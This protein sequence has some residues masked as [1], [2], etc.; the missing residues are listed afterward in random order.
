[1]ENER[2]PAAHSR[3]PFVSEA[4]EGVPVPAAAAGTG[5]I[6]QGEDG[7]GRQ[8][9][10]QAV[11]AALPAEGE[12]IAAGGKTV[13]E[14]GPGAQRGPD[15]AVGPVAGLQ[16]HPVGRAGPAEADPKEAGIAVKWQAQVLAA[17]RTL[18]QTEGPSRSQRCRRIYWLTFALTRYSPPVTPPN[19]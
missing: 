6:A 3:V 2:D 12:Q 14:T 7:P 9:E 18:L 11:A 5:V 8:V 17:L 15:R 1:M 10:Q 4:G 19:R 16:G 13:E